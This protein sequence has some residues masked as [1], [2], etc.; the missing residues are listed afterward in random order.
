MYCLINRVEC[1]YADMNGWC[2]STACHN[3]NVV[4]NIIPNERP[5][6]IRNSSIW[7]KPQSNWH[8]GTPTVNDPFY[9][10]E[11][12]VLQFATPTGGWYFH[13]HLFKPDFSN[14]CFRSWVDKSITFA[15]DCPDLWWQ[16]IEPF[17]EETE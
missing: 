5:E 15:F 10:R 16:K 2:D 1:R 4:G 3:M 11:V 17:V 14:K 7:A 13:G 6:N 9:V 8:T 12:F